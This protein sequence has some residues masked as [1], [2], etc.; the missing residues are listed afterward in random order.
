MAAGRLPFLYRAT[1]CL[2][3]GVWTTLLR[4]AMSLASSAVQSGACTCALH[5]P[6]RSHVSESQGLRQSACC[7]IG[8]SP[9]GKSY[10]LANDGCVSSH[11]VC[12][13][14]ILG[15][16]VSEITVHVSFRYQTAFAAQGP[17]G[18]CT[19]SLRCRRH[20]RL[21]CHGERARSPCGGMVDHVY[22]YE[23][24]RISSYFVL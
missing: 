21:V 7:R 23:L 4:R 9:T 17:R 1:S 3:L 15:M 13:C 11:D 18:H 19:I 20:S 6:R 12:V 10:S 14:A 8:G 22:G 16:Y 2:G 5:G 24:L